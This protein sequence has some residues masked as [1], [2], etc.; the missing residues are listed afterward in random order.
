MCHYML[1]KLFP[2]SAPST[3]QSKVFKQIAQAHGK[4]FA[5]TR[6]GVQRYIDASALDFPK[7]F[8]TQIR[9]LG[10]LLLAHAGPLSAVANSQSHCSSISIRHSVTQNQERM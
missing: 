1:L 5:N 6:H 2:A 9:P 4:C 3:V 10:Q 7:V 8:G